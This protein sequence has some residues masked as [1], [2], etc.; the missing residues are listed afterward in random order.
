MKHGYSPGA[1]YDV[2]VIDS[3]VAA[4]PDD[5]ARQ[6][7][8]GGRRV[9]VVRP[10][11]DMGQAVVMTRIGDAWSQR[12]VFDAGTAMLPGFRAQPAFVF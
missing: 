7:A 12:P 8:E 5:L 11:G 4:V 2:I 10:D 6:L 9:T 3:A 1:P